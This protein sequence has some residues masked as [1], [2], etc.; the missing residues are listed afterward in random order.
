MMMITLTHMR[1]SSRKVKKRNQSK[2]RTIV[3]GVEDDVGVV[4]EI[5]LLLGEL[6]DLMKVRIEVLRINAVTVRSKKRIKLLNKKKKRVLK[7]NQIKN[8]ESRVRQKRVEKDF[9]IFT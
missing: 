4:Q 1:D 2:I 7:G 6:V 3:N 8:T 5:P 9:P